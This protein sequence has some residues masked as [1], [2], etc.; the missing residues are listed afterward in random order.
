MCICWALTLLGG[1]GLHVLENFNGRKLEAY[2]RL[3]RQPERFGHILDNLDQ[4][5]T[6][7]QYLLLFGLVIGSLAA[8]AWFYTTGEVTHFDGRLSAD[9]SPATLLMWVISWLVLL[10]LAGLWLPRIVVRYSS[11]LFLYHTWPLWYG[12]AVLTRPVVGLGEVFSWVGQRLS[13]EPDDEQFEEEMLEDEIR[14]MVAAG[15][16]D[17]VFSQGVPEMIQGIMDLDENDVEEIMTPRS[18]V[19]AI[20]VDQPWEEV[21]R[22][23]ADCGRTRLPV[24]RETKDQIIGI[25][26]VK[27]LL[28]AL[29]S[30]N[31]SPGP[32]TLEGI[33]RKPWFIPGNKTV[34]ELLRVFLHNRNHMAIVV[35]EYQQFV[36]VVTIED[37][38]EE[39]VGEIADELDT[40]EDSD[41]V[42][43]EATHQIE[44]EGKVQIESIGKLLGIDLPES[45]D[46]DTVGG[47][48]IHRLSE[49]PQVGT[50]VEING[51]LITVLKA[52][53]RMVQRVRLE[54]VDQVER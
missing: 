28:S 17:G 49:I 46:Y 30:T 26:F 51:I 9:V 3:R 25:L 6:T 18:L 2:S 37:A 4:A 5:S 11:S 32:D 20:D 35:D 12:V 43:D 45:D 15:Q 27:D 24:Y 29:A 33:L 36:G 1:L 14:T 23:V 8:G 16:R 10:T 7:A 48:V 21:V 13:D 54:I 31:F 19:D 53:K 50:Q 34:D 47:L 22:H 44:A 40:E 41:L 39:I 42:Y 52:T 38:L